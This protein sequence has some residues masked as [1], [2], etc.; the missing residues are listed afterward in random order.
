MSNANRQTESQD[1]LPAGS[2]AGDSENSHS[3]VVRALILGALALMSIP[4][5]AQISMCPK[6]ELSSRDGRYVLQNIDRDE[7][8]KHSILLKDK[9]TGKTRTVYD[10]LSRAV[11]PWSPDSTHC[12]IDNTSRRQVA[13][14]FAVDETAPKIDVQVELLQKANVVPTPGHEQFGVARWL[15]PERI[16]ILNWGYTADTLRKAFCQCYVYTLNRTVRKCSKR[17]KD[18][19]LELLCP[20]LMNRQ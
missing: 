14:I 1:P 11:V 7:E 8:P 3:S 9:T 12:A 4:S 5:F 6:S 16:A 2:G 19:D 13:Y 20:S 15:D 10:Y 17:P 18:S